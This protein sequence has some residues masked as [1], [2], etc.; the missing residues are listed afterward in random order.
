MLSMLSSLD[1]LV[2]AAEFRADLPDNVSG[3]D[4]VN[5]M[6]EPATLALLA[7]PASAVSAIRRTRVRGMTHRRDVWTTTG[8]SKEARTMIS[9]WC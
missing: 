8:F 6:P 2:I 9:F 4:N 7:L 5:M 1:G 3:L